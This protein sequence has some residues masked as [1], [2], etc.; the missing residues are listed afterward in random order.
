MGDSDKYGRRWEQKAPGAIVCVLSWQLLLCPVLSTDPSLTRHLDG[1]AV[2][3]A[4]PWHVS[5]AQQ[6]LLT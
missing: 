5:H 6:F 1:S 3:M 2:W 4:V